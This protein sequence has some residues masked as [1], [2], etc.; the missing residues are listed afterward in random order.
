MWVFSK[1]KTVPTI[2]TKAHLR[3]E[4]KADI[5]TISCPLI[6]LVPKHNSKRMYPESYKDLTRT[7]NNEIYATDSNFHFIR[8]IVFRIDI[9]KDKTGKELSKLILKN[10][11][12]KMPIN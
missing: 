2:H 6:L 5:R 8:F 9:I 12:M 7:K 3:T 1:N 11:L 10:K 4:N